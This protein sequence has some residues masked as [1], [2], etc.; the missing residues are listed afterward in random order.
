MARPRPQADP[1]PQAGTKTT[2]RTKTTGGSKGER[3]RVCRDRFSFTTK[4]NQG[5]CY[6][7]NHKT[8]LTRYYTYKDRQLMTFRWSEI[9]VLF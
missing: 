3:W 8:P 4:L 2:G 1:R 5:F 7:Y 6:V 9:D